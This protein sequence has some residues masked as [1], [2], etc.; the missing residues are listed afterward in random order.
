MARMTIAQIKAEDARWKG[1]S[2]DQ[3]AGNLSALLDQRGRNATRAWLKTTG[4]GDPENTRPLV[5]GVIPRLTESLSVLYRVPATRRLRRGTEM[6]ADDD[7]QA[8]LFADLA[9]RMMLDNVWQAVDARRNLLRQCVVGLVESQRNESVQARI[10]EPHCVWRSPTASSADT[11]DDDAAIAILVRDG[12]RAEDRVYQLWQHED[13]DSW[14]CWMV[15]ESGAM[16]GEQPY[17]PEGVVPFAG[18]PLLMCYDDLPAGAAYL[19]IPESR[20]DFALNASAL[21]N[22]LAYLVK[23]EAHTIKVLRSD[24][25]RAAPKELGPDRITTIPESAQLSTLPQSPHI[26]DVVATIEHTLSMLALSESLPPDYLSP[27]RSVLTGPALKSSERD[28][29]ARRQRQR[30]LAVQDERKLFRKL[31]AVH[32]H[33]AASWGLDVLDE[34]LDLVAMFGRQWQPVDA[35]ELQKTHGFDLA[36]GSGS[37]IGYMQERYN[38]DRPTAIAMFHEVQR[39]RETYPAQN[40]QNPAALVDGPRDALGPDSATKVPGAFNPELGTSTEGASM[41]DAVRRSVSE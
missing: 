28:L 27:K 5:I 17:G 36:I 26:Q 24:D 38:C 7:P 32:N 22:D 21:L 35:A 33:F 25:P 19:P 18:L 10:Y 41:V 3:D 2:F 14:R 34:D 39:D 30:P 23:L 13:D 31:R 6:L 29:E 16:V 37:L 8:R 40:T 15:S 1:G 11:M 4:M 12:A 9:E 20:L